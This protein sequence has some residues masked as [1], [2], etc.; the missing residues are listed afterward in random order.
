VS[1]YRI[2]VN[3]LINLQVSG[4]PTLVTST[5]YILENTVAYVTTQWGVENDISTYDVPGGTY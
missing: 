4:T 3:P 1:E 5:N 2:G